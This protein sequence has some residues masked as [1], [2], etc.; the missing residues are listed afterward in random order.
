MGLESH[1]LLYSIIKG[2]NSSWAKAHWQIVEKRKIVKLKKEV[3]TAQ[4]CWWF[5][6]FSGSVPM[7]LKLDIHTQD[8]S[9]KKPWKQFT[10]LDIG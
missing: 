3:Q 1:D 4:W 6:F 9:F 7:V 2:G 8:H 5:F 10:I